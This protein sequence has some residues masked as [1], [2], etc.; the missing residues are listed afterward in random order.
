[1]AHN[2]KRMQDKV[3]LITGGGGGIAR[4]VARAFASEGASLVLTDI[5]PE[6]LEA[7]KKNLE[8]DF[9]ADV[10]TLIVDGADEEQVIAALDKT[11]DRFGK[12]NVL[13]N[14]ADAAVSGVALVDQTKEDFE[15]AI[16]A[17]L[18]ATFYFMKYAFPYLKEVEGSVINF[19]SGAAFAGNA[20]QGSYAATKE[21][22]RAL[23]RVAA[24]EWGAFNI[25]VNVVAPLVMT[26]ALA[27]WGEENPEM[28]EKN[29]RAIPLGRYGDAEK[30]IGGMCV[31][32]GSDDAQYVTGETMT[33][34]GG[35]GMRP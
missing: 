24:T 23:S 27:D 13:I 18:Y 15:L 8:D 1:M 31:F 12:L 5:V 28:F 4:G 22:I 3:V 11:I 21:G 25:N 6:G 29:I 20:G 33:V 26:A 17:G 30:D 34:Q 7:T 35:S 10:L 32:L 14:N 19:A 2:C 16:G 9:G